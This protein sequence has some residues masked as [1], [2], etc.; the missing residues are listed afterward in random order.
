MAT[1]LENHDS[2]EQILGEMTL[3][4]K[5]RLLIGGSP[6]HTEAFPEYGIPAMYMIDSCNGLNTLEYAGEK[7]YQKLDMDAKEK[8]QPLDREKNNYMGGLLIALGVLQ[9]QMIE[10]AEAGV[11]PDPKEYHCYPPGIALG[12]TWNP[13]IVKKCG[14]ALA[15]EMS[16][17]GI[18]M[19]LGPNVNI[20]RDPL[21]GRLGESFTEDP[22]LM[23]K[24]GAAMIEG[25]QSEGVIACAKHFAAN[26]Q[27]KDRMGVEEHVP[28]R[29][30]REIYFPGFQACI[31]AGCKTVMSAYNNLNGV[32]SAQNPWLLTEIL[33]KEWDFKGFVVSDWG[34]AYDQIQAIA[35]GNDLT[36]PGPRGI[37]CIKD[38]V[39]NGTLSMEKIDE[40]VRNILHIILDS[41]AVTKKYHAQNAKASIEVMEET[42]K[43]SMILLKND[44]SLPILTD[45][46]VV[47]YGK[48]SKKIT[49]CPAGSSN[50]NTDLSTC[51]YDRAIELL[52][53][54]HVSYEKPTKQ[55]KYWI[56]VVGADGREGADR[57]HMRMDE[58]D[59]IVLE[60][61]IQEAKEADGKVILVINA[62]G[63]IELN[64][65]A[66]RV[67]AI[68]C[69]FL[70]GTR[71]GKIIAD[72]LFG[73]FNP[74]GKLALTWPKH[75]YDC[76]AYKN[77]G[78]ENKEVWYGEGI[79]VGYRWYDARHIEPYYPF[80]YGLSYTSFS[81]TDVQI[82][83]Q[84]DVDKEN[85]AVRIT[86]K[87]TGKMDGSEVIQ[88]YIH[89]VEC[90]C[91]RP[92]KEL[93]GFSKVFLKAGEEKTI[94]LSIGKKE[95]AVYDM[96]IGRW[97][98]QPGEFDI[99]IGT[100]ARDI[101]YQERMTVICKDPFGL[102]EKTAI[103][104]LIKNQK[105]VEI[106]NQ[107]ME[108][109]IHLLAH[110]AIEFAPDKSFGELWKGT[111]IQETLQK[112]GWDKEKIA[113]KYQEIIEK[114]AAL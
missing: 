64:D 4:E 70:T 108:D 76:P 69:P 59:R 35:A 103:G 84:T 10:K 66:D 11:Q 54:R 112:K 23:S 85:I 92:E 106:V 50:V 1:K 82:P 33:R 52:G 77:F 109:D 47:F 68:L 34:A 107:I 14:S 24:L 8:G 29:A 94:A 3:E 100:S 88:L 12:S 49:I 5:A 16:S 18:D 61:A 99:L 74:S 27:E 86:V 57:A 42:L 15:K 51:P 97:I 113:K 83:K 73:L 72:A 78:G 45:R 93:K 65:Y 81:V 36:M 114:L 60:K 13:Q 67:N 7:I 17:Y 105:A 20:Q 101:V 56:V 28:E 89:D 9:K 43:E 104:V 41:T 40:S 32:P 46:D 111:N 38:A 30:L 91:D 31:D 110:V 102:N 22:Y 48:R 95:L 58:D 90:K 44:G 62:T 25:I 26:N 71:G 21:C 80:G 87:N 75:E 79:Y 19:V 55:T 6:F 96:E 53:Q 37:A 2:V 63:P 98:T 39:E